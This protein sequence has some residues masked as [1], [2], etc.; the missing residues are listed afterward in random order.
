M[1]QETYPELKSNESFLKLQDE[2]AGT[3]NRLAVARKRYNDAVNELNLFT[4]K[5]TGRFYSSL[6]GVKP[7]EYFKVPETAKAVP[8]V[9][10]ST[11]S[12]TGSPAPASAP[13]T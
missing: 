1:L 2:I 6:A 4:R 11:P 10:F 12:G 9:D 13:S 5:L 8:K 3:E 7:A